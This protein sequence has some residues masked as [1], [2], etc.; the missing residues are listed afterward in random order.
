VTPGH[1]KVTPRAQKGAPGGEG[2]IPS[3]PIESRA[4]A[5]VRR[6]VNM[7]TTILKVLKIMYVWYHINAQTSY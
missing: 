6:E 5:D 7:R 2:L 4:M 3:V 1:K